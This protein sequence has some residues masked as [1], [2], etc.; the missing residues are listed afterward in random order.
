MADAPLGDGWLSDRIGNRFQLLGI[1]TGVPASLD[2]SGIPVE[3]MRVSTAMDEDGHLQHRYLGGAEQ[4]VYLF[5]PDQHITARWL[6]YDE[7]LVRAAMER[8]VGR[9]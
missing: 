8:A 9:A 4:A 6:D 1:N 3:G 7:N 2:V 5:R